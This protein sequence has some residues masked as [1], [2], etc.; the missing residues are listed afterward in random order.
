MKKAERFEKEKKLE[1]ALRSSAGPDVDKRVSEDAARTIVGERQLHHW[2][3]EAFAECEKTG[4]FD[5][6]KGKGKP[7]EVQTG[8]GLYGI[9]KNANVLPQW[10]QLQHEIRDRL[11]QLDDLL[12]LGVANGIDKELAEVNKKISKYNG[13]V[14][15]PL[16]QKMKVSKETLKTQLQQW[17]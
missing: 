4:G 13:I 10:L 1:E 9:L 17:M 2:L 8:N 7:V 5:D 15:S 11:V 6:L 14:P 3:D 12:E 16:F